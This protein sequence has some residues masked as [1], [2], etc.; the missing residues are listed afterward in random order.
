LEAPSRASAANTSGDILAQ[1]QATAASK[2]QVLDALGQAASKLR[3][4]LG[5]SLTN[6]QK[7]DVDLRQTTTSSLEALKAYSLGSK[8][9]HEKGTAAAIPFYEHAVELDPDF[10]SGYVALGKMYHTVGEYARARALFSKAYSLREHASEI[11]KFDI[12][13]MYH[14]FVTGDLENTTRVFHE[15]LGSYPRDFVALGNLANTYGSMGQFEQ[16]ADLNRQSLQQRPDDVVGYVTLARTLIFLNRFAE[17]RATIQDAFDRKID[18]TELHLE[19]YWLHFLA[20]ENRGMAEQVAWSN[21]GSEAMQ[22]MLP[23][24]AS[25]EAYSGHLQKSREL[26]RQAVD[27]SQH[28]GRKEAASSELMKAA[29]REAS[30][31]NLQEAR[32]RATSAPQSELGTEGQGFGALA[33]ASG[34]DASHAES[35]LNT[36]G[37]QYPKGT[38]VQFVVLP[39]VQGRIEL[40]RNNPEKSI[41]LLQSAALYELTSDTLG[42]C[43]YPAYVRGQAY[44][45]SKNGAAAMLEFQKILDHRG[46]VGVCETGA[47]AHLG[48]AQAYVLQADIPKA[49]AAYQDFLTLWKNADLDIPVL[50]QAKAEYA[51]LQ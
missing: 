29:L 31:G 6:V 51:K 1:E 5:E 47:L 28:A 33:L 14:K 43:L 45:A 37:K 35:L 40:S 16:A 30:F 49:K 23:L 27:S 9:V 22:R 38:L 2:E 7:F 20:G 25:A 18:T 50:K 39:T 24:Q 26:N 13:S 8:I 44:L 17:A 11:E 46:I 19:L 12:E 15:W 32:K 36:L 21:R 34:G 41:Q 3:G 42:G 48:L 4:E 10:A